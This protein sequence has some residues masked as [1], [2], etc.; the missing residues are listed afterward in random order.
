[1]YLSVV[2]VFKFIKGLLIKEVKESRLKKV[3]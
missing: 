2:E 3:S 1:M